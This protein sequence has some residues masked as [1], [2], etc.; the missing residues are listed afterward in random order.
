MLFLNV[1]LSYLNVIKI[2]INTPNEDRAPA[3]LLWEAQPQVPRVHQTATAGFQLS[4]LRTAN[5]KWE[6]TL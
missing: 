6:E 3:E 1:M 4:P 2:H 5:I